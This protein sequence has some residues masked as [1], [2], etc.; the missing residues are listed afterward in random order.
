VFR[1]TAEGEL[2]VARLQ[3]KIGEASFFLRKMLEQEPTIMGDK[4]Y[5]DYY[6][7]AFLNAT[8]SVRD[9][10][11]VR[12][13]RPRN[14]AIKTW[15]AQRESNLTPD[16]KTLYDFMH[17]DRNDEVHYTGSSRDVGQESIPLPIGTH[18]LG[19]SMVIINVPH[20]VEPAPVAYRP[21]YSFTIGTAQRS[22]TEA[23]TAYLELLK[24]M[25]AEFAA[26]NP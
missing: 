5:F 25:V 17:K 6:L 18:Y 7:S 10:F 22:V 15:R 14:T 24:R 12:Q 26:S 21:T 16:E 23:C 11:Q 20:G 1:F 13:N 2:V 8:M 4:V 9:G 19:G 3:N